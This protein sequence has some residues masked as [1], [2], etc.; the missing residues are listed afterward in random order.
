MPKIR[1]SVRRASFFGAAFTAR[2]A[3]P[4]GY[5]LASMSDPTLLALMIPSLGTLNKP[6][7]RLL[8]GN[9]K[10]YFMI[11]FPARTACGFVSAPSSS[12]FSTTPTS[13]SPRR[14]R[15]PLQHQGRPVHLLPPRLHPQ[16][17][18]D[19]RPNPH[20]HGKGSLLHPPRL[21]FRAH[22]HLLL[23]QG[24]IPGGAFPPTFS[25]QRAKAS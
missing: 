16:R 8:W 3:V 9:L 18:R 6:Q 25:G 19:W 5:L 22:L 14:P 20:H 24:L 10:A 1:T 21:R 2:P 17:L 7:W 12:T 15:S 4:R 23:P 11:Q 13:A